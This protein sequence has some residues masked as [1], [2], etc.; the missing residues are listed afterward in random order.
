MNIPTTRLLSKRSFL[1]VWYFVHK[2]EGRKDWPITPQKVLRNRFKRQCEGECC[3]VPDQLV[4]DFELVG[5][6]VKFQASSTFWFQPVWGLHACSQQ[7]SSGGD[8]CPAKKILGMSVRSLGFPGG[9]VI[10]NPPA[11]QEPQETWV[12]SLGQ[13]GPLEEGTA[14]YC[15]ILAWRILWTEEPGRLQSLGV[16]K[17]WTQLKRLSSSSSQ[18]NRSSVILLGVNKK[19][20]LLE[21]NCF[22][23]L[24]WFLPYNNVN[25]S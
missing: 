15:S 20:K 9:S 6:K 4:F 12:W 11:M 2:G 22:K 8:L 10:K 21:D 25:Q 3:K 1:F 5:I 7:F 13:E 14:T 19:K 18:G 17:S 24:C 23:M 16:T